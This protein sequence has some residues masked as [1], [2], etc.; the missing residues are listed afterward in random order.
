MIMIKSRKRQITEGIELS[1]QERVR[2]LEEKEK[3]KYLQM[4]KAVNIKY[5][6]TMNSVWG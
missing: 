2:T 3:Y 6:H 1:P 4:L 5:L